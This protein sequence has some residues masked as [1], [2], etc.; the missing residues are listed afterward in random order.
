MLT[1]R[2][3]SLVE[4]VGVHIERRRLGRCEVHILMEFCAGGDVAALLAAHHP[5]GE[6][7]VVALL[8]QLA[9]ALDFLHQNGAVHRDIKPANL[10]LL[11]DGLTLKL[12]DLGL[13]RRVDSSSA[14]RGTGAIACMSA[15]A[16]AERPHPAMDIWS[17]GIVA[18]ELASNH[19]PDNTTQSQAQVEALLARIPT[20]YSAAFTTAAARML[21][22]A[23]AERPS[24]AE[25]L[26]EPLF[27]RATLAQH[28]RSAAHVSPSLHSLQRPGGRCPMAR[29]APDRRVAMGTE[30]C[31]AGSTL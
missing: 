27:L 19:R 5:L 21:R 18:V 25:L 23:T 7:R 8:A 3:T 6:E 4:A 22:L 17:V 11:A 15:E 30:R 10:L 29:S 1:L 20:T 26:R 16:F 12:A 31:L 14:S 28:E 2:H 13:A 9:V 24:A